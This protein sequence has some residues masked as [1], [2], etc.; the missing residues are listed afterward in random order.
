[1]AAR[2]ALRFVRGLKPRFVPG[3]VDLTN[4]PKDEP[5]TSS[6]AHHDVASSPDLHEVRR[7]SV[8]KPTRENYG[9]YS[10]RGGPSK[11]GGGG[12]RGK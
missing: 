5:S 3:H 10:A 7:G 6:V 9:N 11:P 2:A 12:G 4:P 1:T 8:Q